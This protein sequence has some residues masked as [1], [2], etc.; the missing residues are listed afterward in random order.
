MIGDFAQ[1]LGVTFIQAMWMRLVQI[2]A[3]AQ[4]IF[5]GYMPKA[6]RNAVAHGLYSMGVRTPRRRESVAD[7]TAREARAWGMA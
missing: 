4:R 1:Q 3:E 2:R 6:Q 5:T 7:R